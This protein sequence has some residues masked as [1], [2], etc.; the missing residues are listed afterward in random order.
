MSIS[1]VYGILHMFRTVLNK[2]DVS[3]KDP[4]IHASFNIQVS[5]R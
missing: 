5:S 4:R 2:R 3:E 1:Q